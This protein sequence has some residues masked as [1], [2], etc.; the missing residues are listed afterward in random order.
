MLEEQL[1]AVNNDEYYH[2]PE[3]Q[4][5]LLHL[6]NADIGVSTREAFEEHVRSSGMSEAIK[7]TA[8]VDK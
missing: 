6:K 1:N 4:V 2:A 5:P 3:P 8:P 7:N